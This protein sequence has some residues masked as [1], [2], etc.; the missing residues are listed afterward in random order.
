MRPI[1]VLGMHKSGTTLVSQM[2]H[3]SGIAMVDAE[4]AGG[5][6]DG[7]HFERPATNDINKYVLGRPTGNSLRTFQRLDLAQ[8]PPDAEDRA[9]ELIGALDRSH[10]RWG[11]KD[12]RSCLT[13]SFWKRVLPP[14][15]IVCVYRSPGEVHAHYSKATV[16]PT[17]GIRTLR[18]WHEYNLGMLEAFEAA[19]PADRLLIDY[20]IL[21]QDSSELNRLADFVGAPI[22][23]ERVARLQRAR[24]GLGHRIR[25]EA[26]L[27]KL[28]SGRDVF[29][30]E[31]R[32]EGLA[33]SAASI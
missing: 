26:A 13:Y 11:F 1:V 5:Y 2:L 4:E 12:P 6:D 20:R 16:D 15:R 27:L 21:M 33:Q 9:R 24:P 7:N 22:K 10:Q 3:R 8:V 14:H 28:T 30:L 25:L 31:R 18:A 17:R 32:I 29:A 19:D 23:D